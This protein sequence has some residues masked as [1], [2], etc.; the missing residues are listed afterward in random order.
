MSTDQ[1]APDDPRDALRVSARPLGAGRHLVTVEGALDLHTAS[2]LSDVLQPLLLTSGRSV[3][4]DLSGVAFLDSTGLT[5]LIAAYRTARNTGA[6]LAL[7]APGERVRRMLA[8]TG[9]D[10]VLPGYPTVDSV[11]D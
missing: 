3:L 2:Q 8:V 1:P 7:I 10:Q 11:P 5:C 4:V 9:T 6:R